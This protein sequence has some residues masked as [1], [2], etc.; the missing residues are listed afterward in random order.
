VVAPAIEIGPPDDWEPVDEGLRGLDDFDWVVFTSVNGV[1]AVIGRIRK[2]GLEQAIG[3]ASK[4][5]LKIATVGP[6][7]ARVLSSAGIEAPWIPSRFT[8]EAIAEELPGSG[9]RVML[10]LAAAAD[11]RLQKRLEE[12]GFAVTR[13]DVYTTNFADPKPILQALQEGVDAVLLT[14]ASI[15]QAFKAALSRFPGGARSA[16]TIVA[17]IGPATSAECRRQGIAVDVEA[18]SHTIDGLLEPL[19]AHFRNTS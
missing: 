5:G 13:A 11:Q 18:P 16:G 8:T 7:T 19:V 3:Q 2:L 6:A 10:F 4:G 17:S 12:R 14:S 15:V 9:G 1:E